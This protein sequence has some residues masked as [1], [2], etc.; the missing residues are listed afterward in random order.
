MSAERLEQLF[1]QAIELPPSDRMEFLERSCVGD[2]KLLERLVGMVQAHDRAETLAFFARNTPCPGNEQPGQRIGP[3]WLRQQLGE[4]GWGVVFLAEQE[5]P[6]RR[7]VAL[8][9]IKVG[10]DTR[11]VIARFEAEREALARMD[12]PNIAKVLDAGA[13]EAGRPYFVMELVSGPRITDYCDQ[14]KLR[15][16]ERLELFTNV[17]QAVQHAHQ[18]GIIHRDLKPSN[19]LVAEH[20]GLPVPKV[21]DFGIAKATEGRLTDNTVSTGGA[22]LIGTPAYMSPEQTATP[23]PD[24][25]TRSD[26]Y[27]LGVL[28]YELLVGKTPFDS[29]KLLESSWEEMCRTIR[30][31]DP[32]RPA[33]LLATFSEEERSLVGGRRGSDAFQLAQQVKGDLDWIVM[34]CLAK[35]RARRYETANGLA[36]DLRRYLANEPV[37]ARPPSMTYR[38]QK[39]IR[40]NRLAFTAAGAIAG[41]LLLGTIVSTR[42]AVDADRPWR[43]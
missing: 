19:I 32:L 15:L 29:K 12:H 13:T 4:G 37:I 33:A 5:K 14:K 7:R 26:I 11:N 41:V 28:L 34:K 27:S 6:V 21:I 8:K 22:H 42:Q 20:D 1:D 35:E 2:P 10:L 30:E 39:A 31:K 43:V 3:Y 23:S 18:K 17:C 38:L 36:T 9:V 16:S 24:V 40:R 25:D